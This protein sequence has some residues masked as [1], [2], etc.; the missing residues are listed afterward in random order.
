MKKTSQLDWNDLQEIA[1]M[2]GVGVLAPSVPA[3]ANSAGSSSDFEPEPVSA[4]P[5]CHEVKGGQSANPEGQAV[6]SDQG[7]SGSQER[8]A[9]MS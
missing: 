3:P 4:A 6:S 1:K 2:K 7:P 9:E 5:M 8:D